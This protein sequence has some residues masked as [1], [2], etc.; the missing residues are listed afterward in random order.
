MST[1]TRVKTLG[2]LTSTAVLLVSLITLASVLSAPRPPAPQPASSD[3]DELRDQPVSLEFMVD[4][5]DAIIE[6][7]I[8]S[9]VTNSVFAGYD[10]SGNII[11]SVTA[12]PGPGGSPTALPPIEIPI[13]DLQISA[14]QILK[15]D[16][17]QNPWI[18]RVIAE[19]PYST[20]K[21]PLDDDGFA[22]GNIGDHYLFFLRTNPDGTYG[23]H[24][25]PYDRVDVSG[26][27][28]TYSNCTSS[29][30]AFATGSSPAAFVQD[31]IAEV[32]N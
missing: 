6:G 15:D 16:G 26:A 9:V 19:D 14:S 29:A 10:S 1:Q 20:C 24:H 27:T 12:T 23:L 4:Y 18:L 22:P 31:V 28:V 21:N 3:S 11:P 2:T 5:A 13:I 17:A 32:N 30:I 8:T 7:T 25:G